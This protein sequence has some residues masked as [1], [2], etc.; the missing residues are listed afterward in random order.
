MYGVYEGE[1]ADDIVRRF[2]LGVH[3]VLAASAILGLHA[4]GRAGVG[5]SEGEV[6][7]TRGEDLHEPA[8]LALPLAADAR[9]VDRR[10]IAPPPAML[11]DR[12]ESAL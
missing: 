12:A 7:Q 9:R 3:R 4:D 11:D 2:F 10:V 1:G 8:A 6:R 5:D